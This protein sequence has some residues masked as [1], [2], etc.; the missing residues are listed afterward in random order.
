MVA[1]PNRACAAAS[2][3]AA[4]LCLP[5][6]SAG[7]PE[8]E[9]PAAASERIERLI[10]RGAM[11]EALAAVDRL[12]AGQGETARGL[13]YK[14][15][16]LYRQSRHREALQHLQKSFSLDENAPDTSKALGLCLVKLGKPDLAETFFAI[17]VRLAPGDFMAR[18]YLGLRYYISRRVRSCR[19]RVPQGGRDR[20]GLPGR[21]CLSRPRPRSARRLRGRG[22]ALREGQRAEPRK[23][24]GLVPAAAAAGGRSCSGKAAWTK[25]KACFW[26]PFATMR[27]TRMPAMSWACCWRGGTLSPRAVEQ[28]QRAAS[29]APADHRP[30]YAL[31]RIYRRLGDARKARDAV[32]RFRERR[33]PLGDGDAPKRTLLHDPRAFLHCD[34]GVGVDSREA[35]HRAARPSE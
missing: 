23:L 25:P 35:V 20:A 10:N 28:L 26:S 11:E 5:G 31:S 14:G 22:P 27:A 7:A 16:I 19:V 4:V 8:K 9:P 34:I 3:L 17:A 18:Y 13:F 32:N 29:L 1:M 12:L 30:H 6:R 21:T 15:A 33:G 2:L 24:P